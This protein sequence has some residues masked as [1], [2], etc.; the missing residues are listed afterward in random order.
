V[1]LIKLKQNHGKA[2]AVKKAIR[3]VKTKHVLLMDA[4]LGNLI[5]SEIDE[6]LEYYFKTRLDLLI[7]R[8]GGGNNFLDRLLRKEVIFSGCRLIALNY[9]KSS[10]ANNV[11]G[12]TL[13]VAQNKFIMENKLNA[14]WINVS[15][16]NIHKSQKKG[17]LTG[18]VQ[19]WKMEASIMS[20]LGLTDFFKQ[21]IFFCRKRV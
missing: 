11:T 16:R 20:Y 13:E 21:I 2:G 5:P 6:A 9:L 19:S 8:I 1:K 10:I 12:Y 15:A 3:H 14:A 7:L 4:D 18:L 17:F